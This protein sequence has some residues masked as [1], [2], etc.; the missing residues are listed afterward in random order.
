M[1]VC[2]SVQSVLRYW[3]KYPCSEVR[4]QVPVIGSVK[5]VVIEVRVLTSFRDGKWPVTF[6]NER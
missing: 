3:V 5:S 2:E 1:L 6:C 4:G